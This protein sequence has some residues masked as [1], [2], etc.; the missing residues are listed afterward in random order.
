MTLNVHLD[1]VVLQ[2]DVANTFNSILCE[3]IFQELHVARGQL[4]LL[5]HFVHYFYAHQLPL[6]FGHHSLRKKLF[7]I[8]SFMGMR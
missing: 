4:I 8:L 7:I 2:V 3:V 1:W 6:F 5:F